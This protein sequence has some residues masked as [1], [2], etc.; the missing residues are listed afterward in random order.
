MV[1]DGFDEILNTIYIAKKLY[2]LGK[3]EAVKKSLFDVLEYDVYYENMLVLI[4]NIFAYYDCTYYERHNVEVHVLSDPVIVDFYTLAGEYGKIHKIPDGDNPYMKEAEQE[5]RSHLSFSYCID[6]KLMGHTE[7]KRPY[8]SRLCVFFYQDE[9]IDL[10]WLAYGFIEIYEWF[11]D[12]CIRLRDELHKDGAD[13]V[14]FS[15]K[16]AA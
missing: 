5:V 3:Y 7:P 1:I 10:A 2:D 14:R 6:W 15:G 12:A 9:Y 13:E 8:H 16:E 11:S 4:E